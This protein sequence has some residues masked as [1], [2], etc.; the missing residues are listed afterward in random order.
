VTSVVT[1]TVSSSTTVTTTISQSTT[2]SQSSSESAGSAPKSAPPP[3]QIIVN[4]N[5][6]MPF[7]GSMYVFPVTNVYGATSTSFYESLIAQSGGI[8]NTYSGYYYGSFLPVSGC[9]A[10]INDIVTVTILG[11]TYTQSATCPAPGQTAYINFVLD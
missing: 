2:T 10:G 5:V 3:S 7:S 4:I 11:Q 8:G 1:S 9:Q 6:T